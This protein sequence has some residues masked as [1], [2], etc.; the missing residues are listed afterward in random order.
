M[1]I[2]IKKA[3]IIS[4]TSPLNGQTKDIFITDGTISKIADDITE[5]ADHTLE[6]KGLCVSAGWM[7]MF[8]DFGDPGFEQKESIDTGTLIHCTERKTGS[9]K[10]SSQRRCKQK[11]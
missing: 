1:K 11:D 10:Y 2:L 6:E 9:C 8:A 3:T 4:P 5:K 7:D